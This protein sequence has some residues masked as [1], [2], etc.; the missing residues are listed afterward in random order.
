MIA[1]TALD[2]NS[3]DNISHNAHLFGAIAG[4]LLGSL[5]CKNEEVSSVE[6]YWK[7]FSIFMF[8]ILMILGFCLLLVKYNT[9]CLKKNLFSN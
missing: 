1:F 9:I 5:L 4:F 8:I 6:K 2:Y 3:G 7:Q